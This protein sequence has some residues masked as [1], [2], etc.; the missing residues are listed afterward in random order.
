MVNL[1]VHL[2]LSIFPGQ[3]TRVIENYPIKMRGRSC[4]ESTTKK[5][6]DRGIDSVSAMRRMFSIVKTDSNC[7]KAG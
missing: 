7:H 4:D 3:V 1:S 6:A 5:H 2:F